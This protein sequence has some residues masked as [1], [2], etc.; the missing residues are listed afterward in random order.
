MKDQRGMMIE[1]FLVPA[2]GLILLSLAAGQWTQGHRGA[3]YV[4]GA[5][6]AGLIGLV[7]WLFVKG[8]W[9]GRKGR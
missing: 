2:L 7:L 6:G 5:A 1:L 4:L 3:A 9:D 8:W